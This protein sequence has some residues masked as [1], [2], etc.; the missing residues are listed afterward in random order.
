M[1]NFGFTFMCHSKTE[2]VNTHFVFNA[3]IDASVH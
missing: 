2:K 3:S 1:D